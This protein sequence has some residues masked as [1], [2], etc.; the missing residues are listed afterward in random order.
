VKGPSSKEN[1]AFIC[2]VFGEQARAISILTELL[3]TPY[4]S[5]LYAPTPITPALLRIDPLWDGL[6]GDPAFQKLCAEKQP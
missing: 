2:S 6:R 3:Q 4:S 5:W 1:L